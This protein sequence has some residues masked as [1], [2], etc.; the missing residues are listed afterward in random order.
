MQI[1]KARMIQVLAP[2]HGEWNGVLDKSIL[3]G[4]GP[5]LILDSAR[6]FNVGITQE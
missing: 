1:Q 5:L 4:C 6:L 2:A 3:L